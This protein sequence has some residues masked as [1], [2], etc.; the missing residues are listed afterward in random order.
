VCRWEFS[1]NVGIW[2]E[3]EQDSVLEN[4]HS[5]RARRTHRLRSRLLALVG[6][7]PRV[8]GRRLRGSL[9]LDPTKEGWV[10][11]VSE[12]VV[13]VKIAP[14]FN[15]FPSASYKGQ[16]VFDRVSKHVREFW[17]LV[18]FSFEV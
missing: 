18:S 2:S 6:I 17:E 7:I 11:Q 8:T 16:E 4:A 12:G 15:G 13:V 5:P 10:D 1:Q 9:G 3:L 14:Y